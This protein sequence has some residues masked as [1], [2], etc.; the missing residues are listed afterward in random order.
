MIGLAHETPLLSCDPSPHRVERDGRVAQHLPKPRQGGCRVAQAPRQLSTE[1]LQSEIVLGL[2]RVRG[3]VPG[4][5]GFE[6]FLE[7][8]ALAFFVVSRYLRPRT[9]GAVWRRVA[10][11]SR[12]AGEEGPAGETPSE[13]G[14]RLAAAFP[15]AAHPLR[16]ITDSF[17]VAA[18]APG[19]LAH[20]GATE[21]VDRWQQ[22]RPHLVRRVVSRFRPAW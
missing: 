6:C 11:L 12:L 14:R 10:F 8:A 19:E 5:V 2:P 9:P 4:L 15:E 22:I 21:V 7:P 3:H 1:V 20:R 17:V 18:Y 16:E 13:V